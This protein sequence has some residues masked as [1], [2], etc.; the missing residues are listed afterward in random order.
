HAMNR[1]LPAGAVLALAA[2]LPAADEA[3]PETTALLKRI[4][5]VGREGAGNVEAQK[6]VKA[7]VAQGPSALVPILEAMNDDDL[8]AANWLRP[9]F[10]AIAEPAAAD[11]KLSPAM[12]EK[13]VGEKK[14]AGIARRLA[15]EWLAKVDKTAPDR[16]M[17]GMVVDPSAELRR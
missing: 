9:A 16:L 12:L 11:G 14:H 17:P 10:E 8:T 6:A 15:Y 5:T 7:L 2:C 13:F 1:W 4:T 3:R